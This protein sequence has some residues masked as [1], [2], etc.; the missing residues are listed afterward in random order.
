M[1]GQRVECDMNVWLIL[2][3]ITLLFIFRE[4]VRANGYLRT[5]AE[6]RT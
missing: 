5:I 4:L 6:R 3:L 2:I 1:R